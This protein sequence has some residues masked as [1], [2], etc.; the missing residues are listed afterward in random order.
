MEDMI[1][2]PA[3]PSG[4]SLALVIDEQS[5]IGAARRSA[6]VLGQTHGLGS[7]ALG[8]LAIVVTEA[9]TNIVR[10]A[11][12]GIIILRGLVA[13]ATSGIEVL[14]LDKGPGISDVKRAMRDGYSTSGTAGQGLGGMQR[15]ADMFEVYSQRGKGTALVARV[16]N[17]L[18]GFG[19]SPRAASLDDRLGAVCIPLRGETECGDSWRI[20]VDRQRLAVIVVDGLGHGPAAAAVAA[21]ATTTFLRVASGQPET[22]LTTLDA[23]MRGTRGAA[24]SVAVIDQV[25]RTTRFSGV[26]NV[27]GRVLSTEP[28]QHLVPQNGIVGH[29]MPSVRSMNGSWPVGAQ[30]VMH[31]DGISPRWRIDAYPNLLRAHPALIAGVLFRDF[32][33]SRDDATVLVLRDADGSASRDEES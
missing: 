10:H 4:A 19:R 16:S 22:T 8:R 13:G 21:I 25:A 23:A 30:L 6:A 27:D 15:L 33:R 17:E 18:R 32:A 24:L 1:A 29:T 7:D 2:R 20:V 11:T 9:A 14:A 26:G 12:R 31:S 28:M 5:Q 3:P